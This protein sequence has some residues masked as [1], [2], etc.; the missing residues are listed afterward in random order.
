MVWSNNGAYHGV[1]HGA[2]YGACPG[3]MLAPLLLYGMA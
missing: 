2:Y 1:Y 3:V